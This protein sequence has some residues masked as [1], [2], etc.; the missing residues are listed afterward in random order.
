MSLLLFGLF[1][2]AM[3]LVF[4]GQFVY[5]SEQDSHIVRWL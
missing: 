5:A 1:L 3:L 4:L 2:L